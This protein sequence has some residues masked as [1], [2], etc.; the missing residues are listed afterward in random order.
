MIKKIFL[1]GIIL[2]SLL[3]VYAQNEEK[4][5]TKNSFFHTI[6]GVAGFFDVGTLPE[7]YK[8][9]GNDISVDYLNLAV[10]IYEPRLN[11]FQ[12][13]DWA[14][15]SV[16]VPISVG[17][18]IVAATPDGIS[19]KLPLI[20]DLNFFSHST[21]N[22]INKFGFHVGTGVINN[23]MRSVILKEYNNGSRNAVFSTFV[24]RGGIKFPFKSRNTFIDITLGLKDLVNGFKGSVLDFNNPYT[25]YNS[26]F[27]LSYGILLNYD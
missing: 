6:G 15:F 10:G 14:S 17:L 22:N 7:K 24:I 1:L 8:D 27:M 18:L 23:V 9:I 11:L 16:N 4:Y 12:H 3:S 5:F 20:F 21:Y 25:M 19:L 2:F 26:Y 13:E